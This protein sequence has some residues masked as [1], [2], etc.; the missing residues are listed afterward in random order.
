MTEKEREK[1]RKKVPVISKFCYFHSSTPSSSI[2]MQMRVWFVRDQN[3]LS[4]RQISLKRIQK[5]ESHKNH[6]YI[7]KWFLLNE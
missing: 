6:K 1:G 2:P 7:S 3:L 5:L 4:A